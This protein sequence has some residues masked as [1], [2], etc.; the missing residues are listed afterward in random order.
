MNDLNLISRQL[1]RELGQQQEAQARLA[2]RTLE[3]EQKSYASSTVYGQ[4]A[5]KGYALAIAERMRKKLVSLGRGK[6]AVDGASVYYRLKEASM[7]H[8]AV[9][10]LKA[11]L[12]M[13]GKHVSPTVVEL[14]TAMGAAIETELRISWY[15][16]Q[17][18]ELFKHVKKGFHS[19]TGT[20]QKST[21]FKL[22]FNEA[23]KHWDTW[24]SPVK[25]RIG[26]WAL[27]AITHETGWLKVHPVVVGP[28][29]QQNHV[30]YD[31][32]FLE[33]KDTVLAQ[34]DSMAFC[35]WPM[36]CSPVDWEP[37]Q[38]GGFLMEIVRQSMPLVRGKFGRRVKQNGQA[39]TFLNNLQHVAYRINPGVMEVADWAF[40]NFRTIGKFSREQAKPV[41][42]DGYPYGDPE[43]DPE[44][45]R[46][47][48]SDQR[49]TR[50]FNAQLQAKNWRTTETMYV[51]RKYKDEARFYIPWSFDYRGR[52]YPQSVGLTPQ[53]TDFDKSLF[54]FAEEGPVNEY[55]LA[56]HVATTYGYDKLSHDDRVAWA[57]ENTALISRVAED[58]IGNL[59]DWSDVSG[60]PW[61]FLAACLEY[62]LCVITGVK[63]TSGLPVGKDAT[64]SGL[65]HLAAMT[66]DDTAGSQVNLRRT[67][68]DAPS[69]GYKTVAEAAIPLLDPEVHEYITRAT[70]KRTVM[71]VPY[72]V[73]R[74]SARKYIR[75]AL[76][77]AGMDMSVPGRLGPIVD[78]IYHKAV[79][80]VFGGPVAVMSWLQSLVPELLERGD[81][82]VQWTTPSGF[83]VQQDIRHAGTI[84]IKTKLMGTTMAC[85]VANRWLGPD[86]AG[87][88]GA[89]APNLVHSLDASL[90]HMTFAHWDTPFTVIHDCA[91]ARS[92]DIDRL[93]TE[94]RHHFAEMYE[95]LPL[96]AWADQ[97]G[98]EIPDGMIVGD[99]DIS[100]VNDSPYFFC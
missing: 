68:V 4:A 86:K 51:A 49:R 91:L 92:C 77:T 11:A 61:C 50:D 18:P 12:D 55:W 29:R 64:C 93:D 82:Q 15:Q 96:K 37:D 59:Q 23:G 24:G 53:G 10:A 7:E 28:K 34:A 44:R 3:A 62:H 56:W 97:M 30:E 76:R 20:R 39:L 48:K 78:A 63:T 43:E 36:L 67:E 98:V 35:L 31:R 100:L 13:L 71:T 66:L 80:A 5:L 79:P 57:R 16:Q 22:R 9:V 25:H 33:L 75:E 41:D 54:L 94:I 26:A 45:F 90:L 1:E 8:V 87:H 83:V 73:S 38:P 46:K 88:V 85:S 84:P 95:A 72:G 60:E 81:G 32:A 69:D 89:I 47:W 70:T 40:D 58:P 42:E 14:T 52:V 65:Q 17:D 74:D 99:L 2:A 21:V 27:E 19:S 6:G